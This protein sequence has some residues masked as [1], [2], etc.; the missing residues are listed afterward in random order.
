MRKM[1]LLVRLL[2]GDE[3]IL[4]YVNLGKHTPAGAVA[5]RAH[6]NLKVVNTIVFNTLAVAPVLVTVLRERFSATIQGLP[7]LRWVLVALHRRAVEVS[8]RR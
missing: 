6:S 4:R 1:H 5:D 7:G 3:G 2:H 8:K